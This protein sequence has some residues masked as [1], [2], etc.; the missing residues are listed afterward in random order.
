MTLLCELSFLGR[1]HVPFNAGLLA[2]IQEAFPTAQVSFWGA[3]AHIEELKRQLGPLLAG[4]VAWN[5]IRPPLPGTSYVKRFLRE[6]SVIRQILTL[7]HKNTST[8]LVLTSAYPSTVMALKIA[9][10]VARKDVCVQIV[11]HGAS[12]VGAKRYRRP[13][14]RFQDMRT[15][16]TLFGNSG[17]QY[18]VLEE[19]IRK[20][21]LQ[22]LPFL[23][24]K[25]EAFEHPIAPNEG[26]MQISDLTKPIRFGFLGLA[27]QAKGFPVFQDLAKHITAQHGRH[28]EFHAIGH[29]PTNGKPVL[30]LESL[31]AKPAS[32]LI[33][34]E[35]YLDALKMLHF[36]VLPHQAQSYNLTASGVLLDAI[37]WEKPVIAR[38]IPI[39]EA[40]FERYGDIG[41]LFDKDEDLKTS[42]EGI[43]VTA[44]ESRYR[45][46][47]LNLRRIR[48]SRSPQALAS[49]YRSMC[50]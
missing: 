21:V 19:S 27:D 23:Y 14:R 22:D 46:Q 31:S 10:F 38:N 20:A 43:L 7:S 39:F 41:Y 16:L 25:V 48:E 40:M 3:A 5:E 50:K 35:Q 32:K 47:I 17:I 18:V 44:D 11:L 37:T 15:A 34:R 49:S 24:G 42:V 1:A 8:R 2:T 9:R 33:S 26:T 30:G 4:S 45:K 12:G 29:L 6:L 28:A 13:I 36:V